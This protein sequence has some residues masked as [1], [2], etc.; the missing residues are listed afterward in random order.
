MLNGTFTIDGFKFPKNEMA[1]LET[2]LFSKCPEHLQKLF[3]QVRHAIQTLSLNPNVN[4][5]AQYRHDQGIG[6]YYEGY[7]ITLG[8]QQIAFFELN[9]CVDRNANLPQGSGELQLVD[10][11]SFRTWFD[12]AFQR[13]NK[14]SYTSEKDA[15]RYDVRDLRLLL[16]RLI[17]ET[18]HQTALW[19]F[20]MKDFT[21]L[22]GATIWE[23][24]G[25]MSRQD[26]VLTVS[27][28]APLQQPVK[29]DKIDIVRERESDKENWSLNQAAA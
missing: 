13:F 11:S 22:S 17:L 14:W 19:A 8:G 29:K 3:G 21:N 25:M 27:F 23:I 16:T 10:V 28:S 20:P 26:R 7:N 2:N 9:G 15:N 12:D 18:D 4:I 1:F 24:Y 5:D 6:D